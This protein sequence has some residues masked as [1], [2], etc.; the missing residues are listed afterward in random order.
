[1]VV[2]YPRF[3][4]VVVLVLLTAFLLV[5]A[6][7]PISQAAAI[8]PLAAHQCCCSLEMQRHSACC[9]CSMGALPKSGCSLRAPRCGENEPSSDAVIVAKF[10]VILP[11]VIVAL[12]DDVTA[13]SVLPAVIG[14]SARPAEPPVPPPR[15]LIPA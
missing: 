1:M 12:L 3:N 9:C 13:K 14:A 8:R 6:D 4:C 10:R 11:V 7:L 5:Q 2:R 15:L